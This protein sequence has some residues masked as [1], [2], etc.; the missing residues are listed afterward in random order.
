M[1][2]DTAINKTSCTSKED[3]TPPPN[4]SSATESEDNSVDMV[5]ELRKTRVYK[6]LQGSIR[7]T[8]TWPHRFVFKT[9]QPYHTLTYLYKSKQRAKMHPLL[10]KNEKSLKKEYHAC[11]GG[12]YP[13]PPLATTLEFLHQ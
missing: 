1:I 12:C 8:Q 6:Y 13:P 10:A 7:S 11:A 4:K 2:D 3:T 9:G 5:A